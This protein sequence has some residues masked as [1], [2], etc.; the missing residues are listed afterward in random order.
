MYWQI[1]KLLHV[2]FTCVFGCEITLVCKDF[3][4]DVKN[5]KKIF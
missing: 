4:C 5:H 3:T 2:K 1:H